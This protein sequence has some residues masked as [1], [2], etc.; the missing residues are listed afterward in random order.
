MTEAADKGGA[1]SETEAQAASA[2][3][4]PIVE[5]KIAAAQQAHGAAFL[6][7]MLGNGHV[8]FVEAALGDPAALAAEY[9]IRDRRIVEGLQLKIAKVRNDAAK[10]DEAMKDQIAYE[11]AQCETI[12][13]KTG[14]FEVSDDELARREALYAQAGDFDTAKKYREQLNIPSS[15]LRKK[16][17]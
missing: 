10:A 5:G 6:E 3:W 2:E 13:P 1:I 11:L 12:D 15:S 16:H 9:G 7:S 4:A 14:A 8:D 17:L